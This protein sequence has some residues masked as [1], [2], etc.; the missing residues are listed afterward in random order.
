[1]KYIPLPQSLPRLLASASFVIAM[2]ITSSHAQV[3][4]NGN[5]ESGT[6]TSITSWSTASTDTYKTI[7]LTSSAQ[8]P[9]TTGTQGVNIATAS[10]ASSPTPKLSQSINSSY[11][12][13]T[14][15]SLS[16]DF[17]SQG[18]YTG[19]DGAII[20]RLFGNSGANQAISFRGDG[21]IA[22]NGTTTAT[23]SYS[24]NT[25]YHATVNI[26]SLT[27]S[28]TTTSITLTLTPWVNGSGG[29]PIS[30]TGNWN[31][32]GATYYNTFQVQQGYGITSGA[33]VNLDNVSLTVVP[34]P[35]TAG[36][37]SAGLALVLFRLRFT[38]RR[39]RA[40]TM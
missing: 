29:T 37:L 28:Q 39:K 22:L 4:L 19:T 20:I 24:K 11:G 12:A 34:E 3:L 18:T 21:S 17:L 27:S 15:F 26:P 40:C 23:S 9:F 25:W 2:G 7:A 1:M 32:A 31:M 30:F 8:S 6:G 14:S 38:S 33:N 36:L 5:F 13:N 10:G 16:F 35:A